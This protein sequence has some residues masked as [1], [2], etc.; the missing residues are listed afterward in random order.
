MAGILPP[1]IFAA[2]FSLKKKRFFENF[3]H[4]VYLGL[5]GTILQFVICST[6]CLLATQYLFDQPLLTVTQSL[7]L[8]AILAATDSVAPLSL[9]KDTHYPDLHSILF[10]EGV[11]NDA[12]AL[13]LFATVANINFD[14]FGSAIP[15]LF[16]NFF[17][18]TSLSI[19]LG[20]FFGFVISYVL[21]KINT[22]KLFPLQEV[23]M[24][25]LTSYICYLVADK[26]KL[27][28]TPA[29]VP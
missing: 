27:S 23:C 5:L 9:I 18:V 16:F 2:G 25:F 14:E 19:L 12:V 21:K 13:I 20:L 10:G 1:I 26:Q 17:K 24:I 8:S 15:M 28:G 29:W 4:I 7:Q 22:F 3:G 6:F 11:I